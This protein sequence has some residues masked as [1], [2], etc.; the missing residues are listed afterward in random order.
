MQQPRVVEG[1]RPVLGLDQLRF[2]AVQVI[3][4]RAVPRAISAA[5]ATDSRP[6][7]SASGIASTAAGDRFLVAAGDS[8]ERGLAGQRA[9][10][11]RRRIRPLRRRDRRVQ[12][13]AGFGALAEL[14]HGGGHHRLGMG[15]PLEVPE[16][17]E[18]GER[19]AGSLGRPL[20][21]DIVE[22]YCQSSSTG[23]R[24]G[25]SGQSSSALR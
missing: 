7:A 14:P 3:A 12:M 13:P 9:S 21:I 8:Q 17:L 6:A 11:R 2:P 19:P 5:T 25:S 18:P 10:K 24:D 4:P 15:D 22:R 1:A 20:R 23:A 16:R